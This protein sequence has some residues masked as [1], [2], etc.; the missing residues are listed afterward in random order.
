MVATLFDLTL[1][2]T[3]LSDYGVGMY[4][5]GIAFVPEPSTLLILGFWRVDV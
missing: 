3:V 1:D 2:E 5:R 4:L